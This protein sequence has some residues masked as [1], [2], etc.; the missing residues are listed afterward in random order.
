MKPRLPC[1]LDLA[2]RSPCLAAGIPKKIIIDNAKCAV[3]KASRT[4][5]VV[6]KNYYDYASELGFCISACAPRDPQK[7]GRV[8]SGVK[9]IKNA[10]F[11]LREFKNIDDAN[12]QLKHWILTDAGNRTHGTTGK[13]PLNEFS[14]FEEGML[15]PLPC[16]LYTSPSPRDATLSRM[17]SSA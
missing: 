5:P 4:D 15:L 13:S 11:P 10:F 1:L 2:F 17:P 9:Y 7:K 6:Q 14:D 8:E 16:L 3:T 12:V